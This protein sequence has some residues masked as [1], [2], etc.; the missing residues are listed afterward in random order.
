MSL[1]VL[2]AAERLVAPG[3]VALAHGSA[4]DIDTVTL[5]RQFSRGRNL[6][7]LQL[8]CLALNLVHHHLAVRTETVGRGRG[9][10]QVVAADGGL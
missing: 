9:T 10:L 8:R 3:V 7:T 5:L 4:D 2:V 6:S 1:Q